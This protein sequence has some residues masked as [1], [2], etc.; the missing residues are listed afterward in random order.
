MDEKSQAELDI[1]I[2]ADRWAREVMRTDK[3]L[4][5]LEQDLLDA[6]MHYQRITRATIDVHPVNLPKPPD[7]PTDLFTDNP[8]HRYSD[9][10]TVPSPPGGI[11]AVTDIEPLELDEEDIEWSG[12]GKP[13]PE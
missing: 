10:P 9:I 1:L 3:F 5:Y 12:T 2:A 8:T 11:P 7:V 6:V 4:D 13:K